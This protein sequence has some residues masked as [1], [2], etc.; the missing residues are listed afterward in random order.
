MSVP[1]T[2]PNRLFFADL[3]AIPPKS[4]ETPAMNI[5][6]GADAEAILL[7]KDNSESIPNTIDMLEPRWVR[8]FFISIKLNRIFSE[9]NYYQR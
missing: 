6:P 4:S 1:S 2:C 3:Y 5:D 7:M 8:Y 9:S